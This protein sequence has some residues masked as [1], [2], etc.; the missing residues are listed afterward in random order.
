MNPALPWSYSRL[1]TYEK[2]PAKFK[3]SYIDK[4][5]GPKHP[6]AARGTEIHESIENFL[7]GGKELHEVATPY[8]HVFKEIRA[9]DPFVE[10]KVAFT[11]KWKLA[12]WDDC[13]GRAAIDSAYIYGN[14]VEVQEW[15]T[16]KMYDDHAEQRALYL[17]LAMVKW[18]A[19][20]VYRH[21]TYYL[22]LGKKK[23]LEVTKDEL[24]G[25]RED[26]TARV[27]I[28]ASDDVLAARPG[29]Y[30]GYCNFSRYKGGP[31]KAG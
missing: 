1:S 29:P 16:G 7:N 12:P 31:C 30:C 15:K 5:K 17:L 9:H 23:S 20:Q 26:F 10:E 3:Y 21:Q 22:D 8:K 2:C 11:A 24:I 25:A 14:R 13:W 27:T 4:I 28:M 19:G 18:P 6:A